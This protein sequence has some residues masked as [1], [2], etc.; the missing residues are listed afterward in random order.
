[1]RSKGLCLVFCV[2]CILNTNTSHSTHRELR[3]RRPWKAS[4]AN[5]DIWLLLK[6]LWKT[7]QKKKGNTR[8]T[9][10]KNQRQSEW[11]REKHEKW[12]VEVN[13]SHKQERNRRFCGWLTGST[14]HVSP[15]LLTSCAASYKEKR[16]QL[17]SP[18]WRSAPVVW[19]QTYTQTIEE[20]Y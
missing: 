4:E 16:P 7:E 19:N 3:E 11:G 5:S 17:G 14:V 18:W 2:N 20:R 10:A 6:S 12:K 13:T 9:E 1:M 15:H 8:D